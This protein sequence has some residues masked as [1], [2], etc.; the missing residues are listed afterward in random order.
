M[1]R[2]GGRWVQNA[3]GK[4]VF[5][6]R[7]T[8]KT[9]EGELII[10]SNNGLTKKVWATSSN[11]AN[12][13]YSVMKKR[14]HGTLL[15]R[16]GDGIGNIIEM[17]PTIQSI[18]NEFGNFF[19]IH[20][21]IL[22]YRSSYVKG[23]K[24]IF[25]DKKYKIYTHGANTNKY[26]VVLDIKPS[27]RKFNKS[28]VKYYMETLKDLKIEE[29]NITTQG[30]C[31]FNETDKK[32]DVFLCNGYSKSKPGLKW[33][34]KSYPHFAELAKKLTDAGY[35]VCS[36]GTK[37]E[38]IKNT[39]DETGIPFADMVGIMKNSKLVISTDTAA[40][41]AANAIKVPNIV[42]FTAT[43]VK[44]CYDVD[45]HKYATVMR[46]EKIQCNDTCHERENHW[47]QCNNWRCRNIPVND[48]YNKAIELLEKDK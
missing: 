22:S 23:I 43:S 11:V 46:R 20:I 40:Y 34:V 15:I 47:R 38:Y 10:P 35:K 5:V 26:N 19:D 28:E 14:K 1:R 42:L 41:H 33:E 37:N 4:R 48:V 16:L 45:F 7:R 13:L 29:R 36:S 3:R 30:F 27:W 17:T 6:S 32:Y 24:D 8:G 18:E 9:M 21:S 44:R 12:K 39:V 2:H 25:K 31:G